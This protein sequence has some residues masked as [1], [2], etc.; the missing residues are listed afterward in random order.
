MEV[1]TVNVFQ[2]IILS[3]RYW[4]YMGDVLLY[5]LYVI[6]LRIMYIIYNDNEKSE[7]I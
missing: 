1:W 2:L 7:K 4:S 5:D 3:I 6:N